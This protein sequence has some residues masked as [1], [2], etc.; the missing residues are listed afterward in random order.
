MVHKLTAGYSQDWYRILLRKALREDR[1]LSA[2]AVHAAN[3]GDQIARQEVQ[4]VF[5][6]ISRGELAS[7]PG[8]HLHLRH[9]CERV[10]LQPEEEGKSGRPW[11]NN[12][13]RDTEIC[14]LVYYVDQKLRRYGVQ[15]TR[16]PA[17]RR[18]HS[19]IS[20]VVVALARKN[21]HIPEATV[22]AIWKS[23]RGKLVRALLDEIA[24][25]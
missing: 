14:G 1:P 18:R 8:Q 16:N 24:H 13:V 11:Q 17:A 9:Y 4:R 21:V 20:I 2:Y 6:E 5:V 12:Y 22:I 3:T 23:E 15:A 25:R 10:L 19:A 7:G